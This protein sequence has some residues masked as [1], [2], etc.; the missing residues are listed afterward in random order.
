MPVP[1]GSSRGRKDRRFKNQDDA[2]MVVSERRLTFFVSEET[3]REVQIQNAR[4]A[5]ARATAAEEPEPNLATPSAMAR[6]AMEFW[7][8][9]LRPPDRQLRTHEQWEQH[10]RELRDALEGNGG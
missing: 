7:L 9:Q 10:F 1:G 4:L 6:E 3:F 8:D 5:L 2:P